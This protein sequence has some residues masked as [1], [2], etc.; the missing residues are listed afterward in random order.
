MLLSCM[1]LTVLPGLSTVAAAQQLPIAIPQNTA[2]VGNSTMSG[3]TPQSFFQNPASMFS[4]GQTGQ[5][6]VGLMQ[7]GVNTSSINSAIQQFGGQSGLP[8]LSNAGGTGNLISMVQGLASGQNINPAT[9]SSLINT[10]TNGAMGGDLAKALSGISNIGNINSI[11]GI[12][13]LL[14]NS[15]IQNALKGLTGLQQGQGLDKILQTALGGLNPSQITNMLNSGNLGGLA[16]TISQVAPGLSGLLGGTGGIQNALSGALGSIGQQIG[17]Q[18]GGQIGG[19]LGSLLGGFGSAAAAASGAAGSGGGGGDSCSPQGCGGEPCKPC[20]TKIPLHYAEVRSEITSEFA[21]H[22]KWFLNTYWLE[23]ILPALMLM[24]EQLTAVGIHQITMIGAFLDAKHQLE[25]QRLFQQMT[26]EAHKDYQPSEG[27]CTFGT[28]V[29]SLAGSERKSD[30]VQIALADRMNQRQ[31]LKG[32][33]VSAEGEDSDIR[34]RLQTYIKTYCDQ[35]DNGNGLS[36]LCPNA[37]PKPERRNID[38]D[39]TRNVESRLTLDIDLVPTK[40]ANAAQQ[41]SGENKPTEDLENL[42]ALSANLFAHKI[43]PEFEPE[44]F[45]DNEGRVR[46]GPTERY[47]DLRAV[48]AKRSVAQNSFAAITAMR[49][50]GEPGSAPYTKA[51]IKELGVESSDEIEKF[52][53]KNPSYFA[54]MEILTKKIY[55][56][57]LFYTELYDK[58]AN[59]QRKGAALQAI[60]LMQDRDFYN[61]L[62][63]SEAVLAVLLETMLQREQEKVSNAIGKLNQAQGTKQ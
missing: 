9:A 50:A 20:H 25:T 4:G 2:A 3:I 41:A 32:D 44:K 13:N 22:V 60:G 59:I 42:F 39:Y 31:L 30:M 6:I 19:A 63:R 51:L 62:L 11:Q 57:P 26:A 5:N 12:T 53:G 14:G 10:F 54:Q 47:M 48:Y 7:Q 40:D 58:P 35:A 33:V 46:L 18:L 56:N 38:V 29:R 27:M 23:H 55:Q 45:A 28:A 15:G 61:S 1:A 17:G 24:A 52:L 49:A 8:G 16:Q 37:V 21:K 36:K 43:A 34:S